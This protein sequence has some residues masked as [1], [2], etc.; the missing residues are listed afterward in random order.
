MIVAFYAPMKPPGDPTPSGD[1]RMA[2]L[3]MAAWQG[4]GHAVE[5]A[6]RFRSYDRGDGRRQQRLKAVGEKLAARLVRRYRRRPPEQRPRLWFTYHL[7]H[8]APDWLGA[9]VAQAL[10]IPYIV[11][12][13]SY[14]PKQAGGPWDLGHR[15]S[16][17]SL[18][19]ADRVVGFNALDGACVAPLLTSPDKQ[20][21]L[22]PFIDTAP[23][24]QARLDGPEHRRD[25]CES[26]GLKMD[27]PWLLAVAMM[28][29]DQKLHSYRLLGQALGGLLD[30][31]WRLLVVGSGSASADVKE[32]LAPLADR[33]L[34]L[35]ALKED[36]LRPLYAASDIFVWPA[37]KE[38]Y[39][40]V[41]LE[42]LSTGLPVVAGRS[43]G[44]EGI[45]RDGVDGLLAPQGD[46]GA[47][48]DA[49]RRLLGDDALRHSMSQSGF[50]EMLENHALGQ[51]SAALGRLA[52]DLAAQGPS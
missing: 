42:A 49:V 35:G 26:L 4:A 16:A 21:L 19:R 47:F 11:A 36:A 46:A 38:A 30:R 48:A 24:A 40:M 43:P 45:V 14:A 33:V 7:Y 44:V 20:V 31:P 41:F 18:A 2:R 28:R 25:L 22:P 27:E 29:R 9:T 51:M 13:A 37:I 32:A 23:Y 6:S 50:E 15:A 1:R 12:E 39:G 10:G 8:K 5:L 52:D 17:Q 3:L 34:W